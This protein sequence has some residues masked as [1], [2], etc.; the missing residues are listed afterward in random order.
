MFNIKAWAITFGVLAVIV[1]LVMFAPV[2]VADVFCGALYV[3]AVYCIVN[4]FLLV[5]KEKNNA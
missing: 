1:G 4:F 3:F 2:W 5:R